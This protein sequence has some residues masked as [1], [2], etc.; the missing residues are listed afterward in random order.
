MSSASARLCAFS[1][2]YR[3]S[4]HLTGVAR[5]KSQSRPLWASRPKLRHV[6]G[7]GFGIRRY[8]TN[9]GF[10]SPRIFKPQPP[11][12]EAICTTFLMFS[13][14]PWMNQAMGC[15]LFSTTRVGVLLE[16]AQKRRPAQALWRLKGRPRGSNGS[17]GQ[18]CREA[19]FR[20]QDA[21][22]LQR[23]CH[24][25]ENAVAHSDIHSTEMSNSVVGI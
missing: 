20:Q 6:G 11:W 19:C 17:S 14:S 7:T 4:L 22:G 5:Q 1:F 3:D 25:T 15:P 23:G 16:R 2:G 21:V 10:P 13:S 8:R 12:H 24:L 9:H 18:I